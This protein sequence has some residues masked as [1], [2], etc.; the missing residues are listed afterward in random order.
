MAQ[1][2]QL[3]SLL[4]LAASLLPGWALA[5]H[6][7]SRLARSLSHGIQLGE[8][9]T[10]AE[11][12]PLV[13]RALTLIHF[14]AGALAL[15]ATL[16]R[17]ALAGAVDHHHGAA[18]TVAARPP[19]AHARIVGIVDHINGAGAEGGAF[20]HHVVAHLVHLDLVLAG[21]RRVN[22]R[23]KKVSQVFMAIAHI[24]TLVGE[25]LI[26]EINPGKLLFKLLGVEFPGGLDGGG[27]KDDRVGGKG[28]GGATE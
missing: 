6:L 13:A 21:I 4:P 3:L 2:A 10:L 12:I 15:G 23:A 18:G 7:L 24:P 25:L 8:G 11:W 19:R 17:L 14:A 22:N 1:L 27:G 9:R 20:G 5:A 26:G 28:Q 16:L